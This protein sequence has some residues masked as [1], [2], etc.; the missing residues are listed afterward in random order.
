MRT[1]PFTGEARE[2]LALPWREKGL[3]GREGDARLF[4]SRAIDA[5][6]R[7]P[8]WWPYVVALPAAVALGIASELV[9]GSGSTLA[10]LGLALGGALGW[11][12]FEHALHRFVFHAPLRS[13]AGRAVLLIVHGHHHV[14]PRDR[15]RLTATPWQAALT[16]LLAYGAFRALLAPP[17]ALAATAGFGLGY[18]AYEAMHFLAHHGRPRARWLR[19]IRA[20]HLRHHHVDPTSRWGISSPLWDVILGTRPRDRRPIT[21]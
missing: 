21:G 14:W 8:S 17:H 12:L 20:H 19:A 10:R 2:A 6:W 5:I 15:S 1:H 7:A 16:W 18:V 4:A 13:E 3:P 9:E 11:T